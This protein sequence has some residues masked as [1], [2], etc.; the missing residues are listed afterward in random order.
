MLGHDPLST[1]PLSSASAAS[2]ADNTTPLVSRRIKSET[3]TL[4]SVREAVGY[5]VTF[6][7]LAA[8]LAGTPQS[9]GAADYTVGTHQAVIADSQSHGKVWG[10]PPQLMPSAAA[11]APIG[12]TL[13]AA[14]EH[15]DSARATLWGKQYPV[16]VTVDSPVGRTLVRAPEQIDSGQAWVWHP[17]NVQPPDPIGGATYT[18]GSHQAVMADAQARG[19]VWGTSPAL[20]VAPG[21]DKPVGKTLVAAPTQIDSGSASIWGTDVAAGEVLISTRNVFGGQDSP[22]QSGGG[23]WGQRSAIGAPV[24]GTDKPVGVFKASAP[25]QMPH[26]AATLWGQRIAQDAPAEQTTI[27]RNYSISQDSTEQ[28]GTRLWGQSLALYRPPDAT[29][30]RTLVAAPEQ[31]PYGQAWIW[32]TKR[33][34]V[35]GTD[36]RVGTFIQAAEAFYEPVQKGLILT[37]SADLIPPP[38]V[39]TDSGATPGWPLYEYAQHRRRVDAENKRRLVEALKEAEDD[40]IQADIARIFHEQL[41]KEQEQKDLERLRLLVQNNNELTSATERVQ[42]AFRKAKVEQT[43]SRLQALQRELIRAQIEEEEM[44][45]LMLLAMDD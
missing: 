37:P 22:E 9:V 20:F 30:G 26:G 42:N 28:I 14:Q 17:S 23:I 12:K 3:H 27:S 29:I 36:V 35:S 21:T 10:T 41:A 5:A 24:A 18:V 16:A 13:V 45:L 31:Q 1:N 15:I 7:A 25:Q 39:V 6:G 32:G 8:L 19:K 2:G 40:R 43:F 34:Y 38:V 4:G 11:P 44:F 33:E